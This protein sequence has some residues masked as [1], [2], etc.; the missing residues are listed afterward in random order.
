MRIGGHAPPLPET[1]V[2]WMRPT[3]RQAG[4]VAVKIHSR[5]R[6]ARGYLRGVDS[7]RCWRMFGRMMFSLVLASLPAAGGEF[8]VDVH[9]LRNDRGLVR[10]LVFAGPAGFPDKSGSATAKVEAKAVKGALK[11]VFK[12]VKPGRYAVSVL[13]DEDSDGKAGVSF[14]GIPKEGVGVSGVMGNGKPAFAKCVIDV[15]PGGSV[16]V[17]LRYW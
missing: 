17:N 9:G 2:A 1:A 13:H 11:L 5:V 6:N 7:R 14:I 8:T 12:D 3:M 15:A 16:A 4:R 10:A